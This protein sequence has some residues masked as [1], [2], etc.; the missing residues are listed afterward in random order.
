MPT[1]NPLLTFLLACVVSVMLWPTGAAAASEQRLD[2]EAIDGW[3]RDYAGRHGLPAAAVAVVKDG[4][5]VHTTAVGTIRGTEA[6]TDR[7]PMAIGSVSKTMTAFAVLQ[8]VDRGELAL[9]DPVRTHLPEFAVD[10]ARVGDVTVRHLLS[11][12]SGLPNPVLVPPAG[13]LEQAVANIGE[14][15]LASD[16]GAAY[17]Y[18]NLNYWTAARLVEVVSGRTFAEYLEAHVFQPLGMTD[19]HAVVRS[20][21]AVAG[22]EDGHVT[23]YGLALPLREMAAVVGGSGG[24]VSTARDMGRWLGMYQRGGVAEDG[25]RLLSEQL[26]EESLRRQP[27][28]R[29]YGL[30]WQHTSTADP[31]RVGHD[32]SLT[33]YSARADLVASSGYG[34][35]VLL[36]SYTPTYQHPFSLST[37]VIEV[38]EGSAPT[39]GAPVATLIDAAV[40]VLTVG[41]LGLLVLGVR[42]SRAWTEKRRGHP[43]WRFALRLLPQLLVVTAVAGVYFVLPR[44]NANE[45]TPVDAFGLW[46]AA[47][48][49]LLVAGTGSTCLVLARVW[50]RT[51]SGRPPRGRPTPAPS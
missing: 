23:A 2:R 33:R 48:T 26:V 30:G 1:K 24:V 38:T 19:T 47:M 32:G 18:S 16:P 22:M 8:L 51:R 35:V 9:D 13:S 42:R 10:D 28:A 46:P 37:G 6:V 50:Q 12:T 3:V 36:N 15:T 34:V 5:T 7:T 31:A 25:S 39:V 41:A 14:T 40:G 43:T 17:A 11:H 49:L 21:A 27:G 44:V 29:T 20:G 4:Q 45:A